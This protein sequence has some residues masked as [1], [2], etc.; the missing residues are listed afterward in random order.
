MPAGRADE[1]RVRLDR[2]DVDAGEL[3]DPAGDRG[4]L[5]RFQEGD[6]FTAVERRSGEVVERRLERHVAHQ[7]DQLLRD[8]DAVDVLGQRQRFAAF[9]LLDLAGAREQRLEVAIFADELRRRLDA[10]AGRAGNVVGRIAGERLDVDHL[11]RP[12]AEIVE[13]L[14]RADAALL[15]V[16]GGRVVHGDAGLDE[17]HQVLV[18]RHDQNVRAPVARLPRVGGDQVV[19]LVAVLLDRNHAEG[20]DGRPH[21]REL[22]HEVGRR[23]GT[24]ALVGGVELAAERVFRLVEDDGEMGRL[25]A[26]RAVLDEL[27]HLGREQPDRAD[28]QAVGAIVVLLVLPDR[29]KIGAEHERRAVDEEDMVA[30]ADRTVGLGHGTG[31]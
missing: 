21:Q 17:L 2:G 29:L 22:R 13:H 18:G 14:G 28:R 19:R 6:E 30:G 20:A 12:D 16:A 31:E 24:V 7:R 3:A 1:A 5:H 27:Q 25:D 4:E 9:R 8:Q 11:V 15:A 26:G 23:L 10:D